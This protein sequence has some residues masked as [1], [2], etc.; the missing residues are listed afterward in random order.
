MSAWVHKFTTYLLRVDGN[1][2]ILSEV[3]YYSLQ[4]YDAD[5]LLQ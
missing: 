5:S 3:L 1:L 2:T 4:S